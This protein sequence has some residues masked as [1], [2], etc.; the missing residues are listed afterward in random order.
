M[1]K[2][3][4]MALFLKILDPK[5]AIVNLIRYLVFVGGGSTFIAFNF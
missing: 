3:V 4:L 2:A 1:L 5:V